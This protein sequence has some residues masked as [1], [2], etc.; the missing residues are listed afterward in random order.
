MRAFA[1]DMDMDDNASK[2]GFGFF[3]CQRVT[4]GIVLTNSHSA[5]MPRIYYKKNTPIKKYAREH[6]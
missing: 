3:L 1:L 6:R 2:F 5:L 4:N